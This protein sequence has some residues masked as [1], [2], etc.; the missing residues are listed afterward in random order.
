[1]VVTAAHKVSE[2]KAIHTEGYFAYAAILEGAVVK[3]GATDGV[4]L[5]C[6]D[7]D[8]AIGICER[9][10]TAAEVAAVVAGTAG[11]NTIFCPVTV[12]GISTCLASGAITAGTFVTTAAA[13]QVKAA[14][15]DGTDFIL[16]IARNDT[17]N[18]GDQVSILIQMSPASD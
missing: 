8:I 17:T 5:N 2:K 12:M 15:T 3:I 1:M 13:G 11:M 7:N 6:G 16:G 9:E 4:I 18:S 10:V 14:A